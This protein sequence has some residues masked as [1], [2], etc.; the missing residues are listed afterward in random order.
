MRITWKDVLAALIWT[1]AVV[2]IVFCSTGGYKA[3]IYQNF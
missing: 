1:A 3:F 2:L